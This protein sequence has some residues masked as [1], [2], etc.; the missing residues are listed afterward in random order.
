[1]HLHTTVKVSAADEAEAIARVNDLLTDSGEYHIDPFD[2]VAEDETK[3]SEDVKTEEDFRKLREAER[4][5][6]AENLR[7]A[8]EATS[9]NMRGYYLRESRRMP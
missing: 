3:V 6:H 4:Q 5:E 9:E 7:R 8:A 1:M 2:W